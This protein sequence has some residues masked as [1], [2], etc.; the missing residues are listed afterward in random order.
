[1]NCL[2]CYKGYPLQ[3]VMKLLKTNEFLL[4][5]RCNSLN[6]IEVRWFP[7][8]FTRGYPLQNVM[9]F[10][11]DKWNSMFFYIDIPMKFIDFHR[12]SMNFIAFYKGY[13][14]QN[15]REIIGNQW[16]SMI[17]DRIVDEIHW[18][19]SNFDEV[20]YILQGLPLAKCHAIKWKSMKSN[21]RGVVELRG[22]RGGDFGGWAFVDL[23]QA[24]ATWYILSIYI[25]IYIYTR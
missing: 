19:P 9:K 21:D 15:A 5:Y 24:Q 25:Y 22:W 1:M 20:P 14:L 18:S 7:L 4:N 6:F 3:N 10:I 17:C 13:P 16:A 12:S 8:N 23:S 2:A 11:K